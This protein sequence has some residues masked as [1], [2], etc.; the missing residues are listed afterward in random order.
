MRFNQRVDTQS[1][2]ET[3]NYHLHP[4]GEI[5]WAGVDSADARWVELHIA[6]RNRLGSLGVIYEVQVSALR[7]ESGIALSADGRRLTVNSI[8]VGLENLRVY[9]NPYR[10][11]TAGQPLRFA[12]VPEGCTI[13]IFSANGQLL[14]QLDDEPVAGGVEW[15]LQTLRGE[16]AGSGVYIYVARWQSQEKRGK[17]LIIR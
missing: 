4:D 9:P 15:D 2:A 13:M 14:R 11:E 17:L 12:N 1:A 10:R 6:P 16:A 5:L 8:P 3:A 7:S